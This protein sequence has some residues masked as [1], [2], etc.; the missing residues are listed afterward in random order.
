[1]WSTCGLFLKWVGISYVILTDLLIE[2]FGAAATRLS[3]TQL[4]AMVA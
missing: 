3:P 4:L 1:M 2:Q